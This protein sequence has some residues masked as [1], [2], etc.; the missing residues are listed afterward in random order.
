M[1][2]TSSYKFACNYYRKVTSYTLL[3]C[4]H[5]SQTANLGLQRQQLMKENTLPMTHQQ[6]TK[7]GVISAHLQ[8]F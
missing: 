4:K 8:G 5:P 6:K 7:L 3:C 2:L 1:C